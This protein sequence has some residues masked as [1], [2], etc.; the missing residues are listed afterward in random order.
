MAKP[1]LSYFD[2]PGSRGEECRLALHAAGVDFTDNR[3]KG[4][5]WPAYK[6]STPYGSM[7]TFEVPGK[8]L[9]AQSN[10]ILVYIGR[11]HGVH[12]GDN[13]EAARPGP[14]MA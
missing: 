13:F 6:P 9:L 5:D 12:P 11:E 7:P 10:A 14:R 3:I 1:I 8:P 2:F 4:P